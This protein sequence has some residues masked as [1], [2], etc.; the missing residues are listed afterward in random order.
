MK[1]LPIL[2][3]LLACSGCL[4]L[5]ANLLDPGDKITSYQ[6]QNY[7]GRVD[8]HLDSSYALPA[9]M[10]HVFTIPS[11]GNGESSPT[12]IYA[13]YLGDTSR[14]ATDTVI[15]YSHG[16]GHHMDFYYPRAQLLANIGGKN[17]YGVMMM[18]Y[19]SFGLSSGTPTE[20]GLYADDDAAIQ[21]LKSRGLT[22][23]R[24][25]LYGF[26]LGGAPATYLAAHPRALAAKKIILEAP[27][28]S[29]ASLTADATGL[30]MPSSF[31]TNLKFDNAEQ[32]KSVQQPLCWIHGM[33]DMFI[34][35]ATNGE[36]VYANY[37][38]PY[39][40]AHRIPGADHGT[41]PQTWGFENYADTVLKF[42]RH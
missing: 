37:H 29:T 8:F 17:H 32:I 28:A 31:V 13:A 19:R 1:R 25:I 5:D 30:D 40:E 3:L 2:L 23:D 26:S 34:N 36:V 42:I 16:Y 14:I 18:D 39:K 15:V 20:E 24:L 21:W 41:I 27:F 35:I 38:G 9:D 10:I 12:T 6:M 11:Q 7:T 22:G 4:S 33:S